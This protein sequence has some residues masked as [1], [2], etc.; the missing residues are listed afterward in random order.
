MDPTIFYGAR[1][2][3][4]SSAIDAV[5]ASTSTETVDI[6]LLPPDSGNQP[7]DSDE[8]EGDD[9]NLDKEFPND[10]PG[11][12][13]IHVE[14]END[15]DHVDEPTQSITPLYTWKKSEEVAINQCPTEPP[16]IGADHVGKTEYEIFSLFWTPEIITY[17]TQQT[18][19]YARR[20]KNNHSFDATEEDIRQFLGLLL[21]SGYHNVPSEDDYWSTAEDMQVPIFSSTMSREKFRSIKRHIHLADNTNLGSSKVAKVAQLYEKLNSNFQQFGTFHQLLSI[22][23]AMI[24]YHG[25]HSAKMFIKNKPVRFGFKIWMLCSANGYPYNMDIYCG[26]SE[27]NTIPLGSRVVTKMLSII[28]NPSSH[29]VYFDNFFTS[30]SLLESLS[31][32]NIRACGTIR[33]N[34]TNKCPLIASVLMKKKDRGTFD[35]KS[36]G[37]IIC[38]KW[39]DSAVVTVASNY[40]VVTPLQN[41]KRR[42]K[43]QSKVDVPQPNLIKKYNQGMGG[44]DLFDRMCSSYRPRLRNKKWWWNLFSHSINMTVVAAFRFYEYLNPD[45][46]ISHLDF[47]RSVAMALIKVGHSQRTR[48]GGPSAHPI[49]D[50]RARHKFL[51]SAIDA[52]T[53]STST[54]TVDIVLLP[55]DS[56]NQP[57]DSDE[58]EGDDINLD[59]E[60]PNDVP[61]E[62]EIHVET[63]NDDDH[64]DEPTQSITP[65]YTWKKSEEVAINQCP[66]EPPKIGADHVGKTEYEIFSLFWTPEIITYITQQ[67]LLYARRDKNNH[68][69]DAT[70][71]DIRQFLGLLL[72]S[73]YHNVPSEDDYWS[74]AEDMQVPIFSST[75]SREKFRSI[76][77]HIHLAD[78]TNLGSSKVAKVAQLYEKLNSN[79]QQFGTFHQLLSIDEAMIP[80]HGHHSAKMF[81]KNKPVRFGFK[82]WMLCS[83]NGYPY[84]MDIYCGKSEQNTIPLGS[85][86]VTKMLSIISNP[87]SHVVYFDNFFTSYS[88]L[89]SLS[90]KNIR[91]CGTIRENRTNKCPLIASVLMKKKDRG[92]FDYKSDGNIICV[93]WHDSAVVTVASNYHVVTPLQNTKRRMKGQSKVDV[94]QPNLI[95]KYNQGMGGVDLFDRMCSS[96]RPRLRNKKWWWNLFS[97]SINM[98]VVAAFRFYEYLNPDEN[99]SHLDFRRSVAMA[100]I[101]V[102]HSQRT[103]RGGPSAHPIRDIRYDDTFE[104]ANKK[105]K[106]FVRAGKLDTTDTDAPKTSRK[107]RSPIKHGINHLIEPTTLLHTEPLTIVD[108]ENVPIAENY[109]FINDIAQ[110]V[111]PITEAKEGYQPL[112]TQADVNLLRDELRESVHQNSELKGVSDDKINVAIGKWFRSKAYIAKHEEQSVQKTLAQIRQPK[113]FTPSSPPSNDVNINNVTVLDTS[114]SHIISDSIVSNAES[115]DLENV[116]FNDDCTVNRSFDQLISDSLVPNLSES[117]A[118]NNQVFNLTENKMGNKVVNL[119]RWALQHNVSHIAV[120]NLLQL[121]RNW[122]P[123]ENFPKCARTLLGTPQSSKLIDIEGGQLFHFGVRKYILK[124]IER[125]ISASS[126]KLVNRYRDL[127]N[128]ITIT[129]GID[130]LPISHSSTLQFWPILGYIDGLESDVFII[131]LFCGDSKPQNLDEFLNPFIKE[132]QELEKNGIE[133]NNVQYNVR[134]GCI[135]ADAP[136]RSYVKRVKNHNAYYGCER[137][138]RKR[139]WRKRVTYAGLDNSDIYSDETFQEQT[140]QNH[141]DGLTP[142]TSLDI[143]IISQIPID[144]MHLCCLGVMRKMLKMWTEQLPYKLRPKDYAFIKFKAV[145]SFHF[146]KK[147][148]WFR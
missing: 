119:K 51:S 43:G 141:H 26:K 140:Y 70:E 106:R 64:V 89:E 2:K 50:I 20:D 48:R 117:I 74:T 108:C 75:M 146:S 95:K 136:A 67:T 24:P 139:K 52:V 142:L 103:R 107:R 83:A 97:H 125:G 3:F 110:A 54:E 39:H 53:A 127:N 7:I 82:I 1:H 8:D 38:V 91:A 30:Y 137:C 25:H 77:R 115:Q 73:G 31:R 78:N 120:N 9:I 15:D 92:T 47:R 148:S 85:R 105:V 121:L 10:V 55:P 60:F 79:F 11:E 86:V 42:M 88:L 58:D 49:R 23:E 128:L 56:G 80:Y 28:S 68:S 143:G 34:R 100:L 124:G 114:F 134:I 69:F 46:N 111:T 133:H 62:V 101:K 131:S 122:L 81:I 37:N 4:L 104:K 129:V 22:D 109:S 123:Y 5:T 63:E 90:R 27:Q 94:P 18:L 145:H 6:V 13:E 35:Y 102:G 147:T 29:V 59:K 71:E 32:K 144:Y 98:T 65:L 61:G 66:T 16:K 19:L 45:E 130:G 72:I 14:T 21:I 112:S 17:I 33:E 118:E 93:K 135:V 40:H 84:N 126:R 116:Q 57:I 44:V 96:Y 87:S 132:F 36:D 41:T 99:I 12:V 113:L 76:K 138:C